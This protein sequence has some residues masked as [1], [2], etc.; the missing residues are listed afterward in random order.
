MALFDI[1]EPGWR[2]SNPEKRKAAA[3]DLAMKAIAGKENAVENLV[4]MLKD[5]QSTDV[6]AFIANKLGEVARESTDRKARITAIRSITDNQVLRRL[7][8][9]L[10]DHFIIRLC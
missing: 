10:A 8:F 4:R 2:H 3:A 6:L 5:E 9:K 1:L 7:D